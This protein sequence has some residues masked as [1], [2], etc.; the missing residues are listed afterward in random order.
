[1]DRDERPLHHGTPLADRGRIGRVPVSRNHRQERS[2]DTRE[3]RQ[4]THELESL[5]LAPHGQV[6]EKA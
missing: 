3:D 4:T 2:E 6:G 1:M 5:P